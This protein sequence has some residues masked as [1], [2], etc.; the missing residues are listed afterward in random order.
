M[1]KAIGVEFNALQQSGTWS[2][3]PPT[4]DM[5]ILPNKWVFKFKKRSDGII[6]RYK[7]CIVANGY[8]QQEGIDYT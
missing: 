6:E 2:L 1:A 8:H 7:A 4:S 3:V 5:N